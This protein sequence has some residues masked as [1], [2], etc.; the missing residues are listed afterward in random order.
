MAPPRPVPPSA[1]PGA[2]QRLRRLLLGATGFLL[3]L[4]LW[5]LLASRAAANP[6]LLPPPGEVGRA[7]LELARGGFLWGDV[8]ASL[9]R[10]GVG[11]LLAATAGV[12]L[13]AALGVGR[14]LAALFHPLLEALRPI[15]P[16]A[17][18]PL[19]IL[20]FGIGDAP[21]YFIV[22]IGAFFPV[23]VS[24]YDGIRQVDPRFVQVA[25]CLGA[26]GR[27]VT[28]EV[29]LPAALPSILTGLRVGLGFGWMAVVAAELVAA[30]SGLGYMIQ[31]NRSLLETARVLV[32]MGLI[33][34]LGYLMS[35]ALGWLAAVLFPWQTGGAER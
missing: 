15:P 31:V 25:R 9:R 3:L 19:A 28:L 5:Q 21:S 32:G 12:G 13:G 10:V 24:T 4:G 14:R 23:F 20:W 11:F 26:S 34:L 27:R 1:R 2:R 35:A 6:V 22:A 30:R 7:A 16:I 33:G 18:I 8:L 17:W 29:V